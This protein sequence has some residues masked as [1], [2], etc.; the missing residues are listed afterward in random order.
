MCADVATPLFE[1][2]PLV[3]RMPCQGEFG[4]AGL[5]VFDGR[6]LA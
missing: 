5:W 1:A 6:C 2:L 3:I 4:G